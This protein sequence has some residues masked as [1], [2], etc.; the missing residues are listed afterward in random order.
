MPSCQ[1]VRKNTHKARSQEFTP[2]LDDK[3]TA[4]TVCFHFY[5]GPQ[6]QQQVT[7]LGT[8]QHTASIGMV[9]DIQILFAD[10]MTELLTQ[11]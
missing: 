10:R 4:P 1:L 3:P 7:G 9:L 5:C 11:T 8:E 2:T 6:P